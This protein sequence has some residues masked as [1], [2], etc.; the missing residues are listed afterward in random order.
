MSTTARG[1]SLVEVLVVMALFAIVGGVGL[2]V[3]MESYRASSYHSD[4][5]LLVTLLQRARVQSL[6]N[7]CSSSGC[8]DGAPHGVHVQSDA[9]ILFE[10]SS[11]NSADTNNAV[12]GADTNTTHSFTGD[13]IFSQLSATTSA[14]TITLSGGGRTSDI[15]VSSEGGISWTN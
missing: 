9:Y 15:T 5:A 8:T 13:V 3:S 11:Y 1:F 2:L 12:F 14:T 4:R 10:G 7:L 6:A